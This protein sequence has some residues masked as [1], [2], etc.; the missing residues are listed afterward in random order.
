MEA[1]YKKRILW[2]LAMTAVGL[3]GFFLRKFLYTGILALFLLGFG[4]ALMALT[5]IRAKA[6]RRVWKAV[7]I[8]FHSFFLLFLVSFLVAEG[9]VI[10]T[11]VKS[12][13]QDTRL[14]DDVEYILVP[15]AGLM[16]ENPSYLYRLR[17]DEALTLYKENPGCTIVVLGGQGDD[18]LLP[19]AEAGK[20]YLIRKGVP[21]GDVVAEC[22]S[23]DTAENLQNFK[24]MFPGVERA[25]LVSNDF[26]V[27]RC[28][29]LA[30]RNGI[31]V[32]PYARVTGRVHL[33][34]NYFAREYISLVIYL[35]ESGG[36]IIDTAN[37]HLQEFLHP[38]YILSV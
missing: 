22:R 18:E 5:F 21:E 6:G 20:R 2:G 17:L 4:L 37:F 11:A 25:A 33:S 29:L 1:K 23:L 32:I 3:A 15:G 26:H 13:R 12:V 9:L 35:I 19:E 14:P 27:Y 7:S 38:G 10:G 24:A 28:S 8:T 36:T 16:G 34:L 31:E 30:K